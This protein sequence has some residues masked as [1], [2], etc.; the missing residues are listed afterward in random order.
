VGILDYSLHG[1]YLLSATTILDLQINS[2]VGTV[3]YNF[4]SHKVY[5]RTN[6]ELELSVVHLRKCSSESKIGNV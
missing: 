5:C 1:G 3:S 2:M 6:L 4:L